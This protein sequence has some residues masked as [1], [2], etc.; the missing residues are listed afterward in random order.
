M[1]QSL[2]LS[3]LVASL[4]LCSC[5]PFYSPNVVHMPLLGQKNEITA[6]AHAGING[7]DG[8]VAF[9]AGEHLGLM[10]NF[11]YDPIGQKDT[12]GYA[13]Y[14][15]NNAGR[16]GHNFGEFGAGYFNAF[17]SGGRVEIYGGFGTGTGKTLDY[18]ASKSV[19][20]ASA[21]YTRL[22]VQPSVGYASKYF[23]AG[24]AMR[25]ASVRLY[26]FS[27]I[28]SD[29]TIVANALSSGLYAEPAFTIAFGGRNLKMQVQGGFSVPIVQN[30]TTAPYAF[31]FAQ[32]LILSTG[33]VY[34]FVP[35]D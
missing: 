2:S 1:K 6:G 26:N 3:F 4:F 19:D 18:A 8:T 24:F 17:G 7:F 34:R 20:P 22:F 21:T 16:H 25:I 31:L 29:Y 23:S 32:P 30:S 12:S 15:N 5:A 35:A 27:N 33:L 14:S 13:N 11:S 10:G 9:A 28:Q